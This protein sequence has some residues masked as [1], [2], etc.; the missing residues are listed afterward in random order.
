[1][2]DTS[3]VQW[4]LS[5]SYQSLADDYFSHVAPQPVRNPHMVLYNDRYAAQLKL[6][7]SY[8]TAINI[9]SGNVMPRGASPIA[10]AYAGHQFGRFNI[11]GDGRAHLLGEHVLPDGTHI[12]VQLKGSGITPYSRNG[13]GRAALGPMLREYIISEAMYA[14]RIPTTRSLCV[15][16]TG[17]AV[18][19]EHMEQGAVLARTAQSHI[20]V[21]TFE[22]IASKKDIKGLKQLAD[23]AIARH[24]PDITGKS[25]RYVHFLAAVIERQIALVVDWMRIGFIH[26]VMNTDNVSIAGET[27][28]YGPCAFM[29][30]YDPNTVFSYI[31]QQGRYGFSNQAA[32]TGW[33]MARFAES[34]IPL[35]H[36]EISEAVSIAEHVLSHY[37]QQFQDAWHSMMRRKLGLPGAGAE[38]DVLVKDFLQWMQRNQAD[39]TNSFRMLCDDYTPLPQDAEFTQWYQRWKQR[40]SN[41][42]QARAIMRENNPAVIPRNHHVQVALSQ[43]EKGNIEACHELLDIL[44]NP[45]ERPASDYQRYT[46]PPTDEERVINTFCGT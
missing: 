45:Y 12:D 2:I 40:I 44:A 15:V 9:F 31:D 14:L 19:R 28:D 36:E 17:E 23:Y 24:Y 20:R 7:F 41:P 37:N 35:L 22:Y 42:K 11:L 39:Y 21:G 5:H 10:Q 30:H 25:Q 26:G 18:Y 16:S 34:I 6:D 3:H 38:D 46:L 27:L 29:D 13:D 8:D 43:A 33:N 32:I 4:H 1:M